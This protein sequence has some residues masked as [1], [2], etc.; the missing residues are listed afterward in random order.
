LQVCITEA[1]RALQGDGTVQAWG[2][3]T[4]RATKLKVR[5]S[6]GQCEP[7][8]RGL[9]Q[10]FEELQGVRPKRINIEKKKQ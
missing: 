8:E 7:K 1:L 10:G 5:A 2:Q 3:K 6:T 4:L 9:K